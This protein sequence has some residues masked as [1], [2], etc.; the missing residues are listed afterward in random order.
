M[1]QSRLFTL[2]YLCGNDNL[3]LENELTPVHDIFLIMYSSKKKVSSEGEFVLRRA[4]RKVD[5][6]RGVDS[7]NV[8]SFASLLLK[9]RASFRKQLKKKIAIII[10]FVLPMSL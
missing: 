2:Q 4:L 3:L 1:S 6:L 10:N 8:Q 5:E 7:K 9:Y